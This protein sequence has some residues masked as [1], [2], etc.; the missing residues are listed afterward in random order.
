LLFEADGVWT[1][2]S[3]TVQTD[4]AGA[5]VADVRSNFTG[6]HVVTVTAGSVSTTEELWFAAAADD[7]GK[8]LTLNA[9]VSVSPGS[10]LQITGSL[11]DAFGNPVTADGTGEDLVF[12]YTGPGYAGAVPTAVSA[13]GTFSYNV[14]LGQNDSGT[15]TITV[16]YDLNEDGDFADTGDILVSKTVIIGAAPVTQKVNAGSFKGFVAVY[17][18]G[19]EGKRLSAKIGKDWIIV[20]AIVNNQENGTLYRMTDFTGAGVDIAVR[21]YI[22]RVLIDTINLTTK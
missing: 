1:V 21:I 6:K 11:V 14:L 8:T 17:A 13:N 18:K 10:T 20:P 15:S 22:D 19:Y 3:I 4:D 12:T 16:G 5:Y 2:G 7:A 9:P